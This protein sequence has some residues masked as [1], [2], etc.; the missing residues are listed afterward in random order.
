GLPYM[1]FTHYWKIKDGEYGVTDKLIEDTVAF[2][3]GGGA[4]IIKFMQHADDF[5]RICSLGQSRVSPQISKQDCRG[6][7]HLFLSLHLGK[8]G[9]ADITQLRIH[10]TYLDPK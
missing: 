7:N 3:Y 1:V 10:P 8:H 5:R 6:N 4:F 2:P 9:L